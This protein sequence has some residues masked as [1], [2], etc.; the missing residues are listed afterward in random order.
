M[1]EVSRRKLMKGAAVSGGALALPALGAPPATAAPAAGPEDLPGPAAAAAGRRPAPAPVHVTRSDPRYQGLI[2][3]SNQRWVGN[4][5]Y[6]RVVSSAGQ[7]VRAVQEA[8]DKGLKIAVRSG[9]H[10]DE[11]FVANRD[12]RVVIDMAGM[13]SVTYD[14]ERRAFAVGPGARLGTVYRTLYKRW[15]VVL[16]GGTCPTV[17]AG[18]HITGGGYGALSRSRGL[19]VDHLYAVEVVHVDARGR[20]RKVVATREEDDPNRE[21]WWAHTGAGGGNFGVITRYWLRSP[22]AVG[23]DPSTLLPAA[24]S[25]VLLS[26]VSWSWD[27]LDEASFTRLLRNFTE[28]HAR[29][30]APDSPG[31]FL[32][33]QLKTMHKAAGY[34]RMST[35]VDAAAPDADRL[36]DDYLAA[37]SEGTGVTYHVGDR[38]RAP[39]LYAVTEWSGFVEASVPRW[40]SKSAYVREVMPEEQLRAVYRQLTRD[41]YPGPYGMIAI[42]GFGGKINEVAPGD[43]ATA[44]RDS[45]AKMLYCSLWSDPADDALHQRWIREAYEDVY[46]S[47]GGVPRPGGVNDGCYINYADADL[48]DPALN[49]SG[50]PW[51]ELYFK[52]NYPRLQRVKATWDPRNVFSHRLGIRKP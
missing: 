26:D 48:A 1:T 45:I 18:G 22:D 25:E 3:G 23:D 13:D 50:I 33:S 29:N 32:F 10:C 51:H 15:G 42:V 14:R 49:R 39:W 4:P 34:F 11:D 43:T 47:T 38:Y 46:A 41:D 24:P 7:V 40:K 37:I 19:T 12:V 27:D 5:D 2:S 9:G 31:R 52:G 8:V 36:L 6:I 20:A 21:L 30:S 16:P 28:W 35:Q 17:G 44:Q